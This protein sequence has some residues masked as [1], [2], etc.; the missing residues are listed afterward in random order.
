MKALIVLFC[1]LAPAAAIAQTTGSGSM[2]AAT[3]TQVNDS[4]TSPLDPP[5]ATPRGTMAAIW[6]GLG[7]APNGAGTTG[8]VGVRYWHLGLEFGGHRGV[9]IPE[10]QDYEI[11][12]NDYSLRNYYD[13]KI[14]AYGL[15]FI[16]PTDWLALYGGV[17]YLE[18]RW[19]TLARSNATGWYYQHSEGTNNGRVDYTAG[20]DVLVARGEV[21]LLLGAG[22]S[23]ELGISGKLGVG[24][25]I[26]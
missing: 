4:S 19:V 23:R 18:D 2:P 25:R 3:F 22:Y 17:G 6:F 13:G 16:D 11:P 7:S 8:W 21:Q 15:A 5:P 20:A 12:H 26:R 24:G 14:G 9:A 1:L 10:F